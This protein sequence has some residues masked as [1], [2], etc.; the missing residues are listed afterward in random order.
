[1]VLVVGIRNYTEPRRVR[2]G[3]KDA[4]SGAEAL[5]PSSAACPQEYGHRIALCTAIVYYLSM[6]W[7][8]L[9]LESIALWQQAQTTDGGGPNETLERMG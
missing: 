7:T 4:N 2:C 6:P 9:L 5:S 1:M 3:S 8:Y